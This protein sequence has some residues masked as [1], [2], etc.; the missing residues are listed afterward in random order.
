MLIK[1][2]RSSLVE[3]IVL[4]AHNEGK[5]FSVIVIDSRPLLEGKRLLSSLTSTE[6]PIPCTYGLLSA[7][8]SLVSEATTV[9][10]GAHSLHSN[11]TVYSRAGTAI[12]AMMAKEYSVPVI[13]CCE[14]YKFSE[15]I[16]LDGFGKN[17]L[18]LS[19]P[20]LSLP[21][22]L[23]RFVA[24]RHVAKTPGSGVPNLEI[25]D[26]LFDLTPS[27]SITAVVTEVGLIP[28]SSISSIPSALGRTI[29]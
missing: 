1:L 11:G 25:L 18:G 6:P 3:Q 28:P 24:P 20:H 29:L 5:R 13:A 9:L 16:M 27:S 12:V 23:H 7:L 19:C 17:E 26:P 15:N 2:C 22:S 8:P 4:S 14:T 21:L 10:I